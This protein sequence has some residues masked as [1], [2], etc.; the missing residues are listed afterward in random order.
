MI[1]NQKLGFAQ[2]SELDSFFFLSPAPPTNLIALGAQVDFGPDVCDQGDQGI[3]WHQDQQEGR[4]NYICPSSWGLGAIIW[5]GREA[6]GLEVDSFSACWQPWDIYIYIY[7]RYDHPKHYNWSNQ[8]QNHPNDLYVF[9]TSP[10]TLFDQINFR[11]IL[12]I[13]TYIRYHPKHYLIKSTSE[14][15]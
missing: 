2:F 14:S 8:L 1:P 13:S 7:I 9:K 4:C 3:W 15:S 10:K 6:G 11:I 12:M 5:A